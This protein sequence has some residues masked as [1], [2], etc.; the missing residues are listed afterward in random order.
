MIHELQRLTK[1]KG[2]GKLIPIQR[3]D[4]EMITPSHIFQVI[5][6]VH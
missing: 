2:D 6:E 5:K 1:D 4:G 3:T